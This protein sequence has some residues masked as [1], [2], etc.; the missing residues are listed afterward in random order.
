[1]E[2]G[3]ETV[4]ILEK[5]EKIFSLKGSLRVLCALWDEK[6]SG[7]RYSE[8]QKKT[9]LPPGTLNKTLNFLIKEGFIEV[10]T[11]FIPGFRRHPIGMYG[12]TD[13][14]KL[15]C[16]KLFNTDAFFE[17]I[18]NNNIINNLKKKLKFV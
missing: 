12:L 16:D 14:G 4:F 10:H 18:R 17:V 9:K 6:S 15:F 7:L 2:I 3:E 8:I 1:M 5:I 11:K 13:N